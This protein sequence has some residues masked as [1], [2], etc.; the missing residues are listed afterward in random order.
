M[1]KGEWRVE[2]NVKQVQMNWLSL[3]QKAL[4][5]CVEICSPDHRDLN[6]TQNDC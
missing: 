1:E 2:T 6:D 4:W 5:C 3:D